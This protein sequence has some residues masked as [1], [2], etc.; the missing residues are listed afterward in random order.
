[1]L[2]NNIKGCIIIY[3]KIYKVENKKQQYSLWATGE[4]PL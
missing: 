1:M 4:E 3:Y 2:A